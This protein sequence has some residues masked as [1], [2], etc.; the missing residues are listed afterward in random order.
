MGSPSA[1]SAVGTRS[2]KALGEA[3]D[4]DGSPLGVEVRVTTAEKREKK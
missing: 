3:G 4:A 1:A 2:G